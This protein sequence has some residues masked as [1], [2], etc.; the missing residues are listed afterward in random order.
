MTGMGTAVR[1]PA[2][3]LSPVP[4]APATHHLA[5]PPPSVPL[6]KEALPESVASP[7]SQLAVAGDRRAHR[8]TA[9][10]RPVL[11]ET[12]AR[13]GTARCIDV[14]GGGIALRTDLDLAEKER[15]SIYFELPIGVAVETQAEVLR[16]EGEIVALR[17][18]DAPREAVIAVRSFCRISST[19]IS[20]VASG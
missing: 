9:L 5:A 13:S 4:Q 3:P 18:V 20:R 12:S 6:V 2:M 15:V 8:R 17:F 11:V 16:R 1:S 14:G 19:A 7:S 10:D